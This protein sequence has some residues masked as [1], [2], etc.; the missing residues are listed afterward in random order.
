MAYD[1]D[2]PPSLI[3]QGIGGPSGLRWFALTWV[4][5][6]ADVLEPGYI[7]NAKEIGLRPG[8]GLIYKDV[9]RGE[10]DHYD[11]ICLEVDEDGA[12]T[13]AFPEVPEEAMPYRDDV[14]INDPGNYVMM[15]S[16]GRQVR[17]DSV[18]FA[19][20]TV[21]TS[22]QEQAEAGLDNSTR[23]SPLRVFQ[24]IA[25]F[26]VGLTA[27]ATPVGADTIL[28]SDSAAGGAPK[29]ITI[30]QLRALIGEPVG[31]ISVN[32]GALDPGCIRWG[33]GGTFDRAAR[34]ALAAW[35]DA[36]GALYGLSAPQIAAGTLPDWRDY[37]PRTAGGALGPAVGAKQEDAL[38]QHSHDAQFQT[39]ITNQTFAGG[40]GAVVLQGAGTGN[41]FAQVVS[42][43]Y[44]TATETRVKSFGVRWQ[45]KAE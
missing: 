10:W 15:F 7:S 33:E 27:K 13:I 25:A 36:N 37:S 2:V 31:R 8:D 20:D 38:R 39:F 9:N 4:D 43:A 3:T 45:I 16:G 11:L 19:Q 30:N 1:P 40:N 12:A 22:S 14:D 28:I 17:V 32:N 26:V 24:A 29:E 21:P 6:I 34:P 41:A 5:P 42:P 23:M 18:N 35:L 44:P